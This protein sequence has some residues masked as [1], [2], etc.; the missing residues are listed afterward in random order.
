ME[1]YGLE[2]YVKSVVAVLVDNDQKKKY[3]VEQG[4]AKR[5]TL[6]GV[7]DHV[8]SPLAGQGYNLGNVG[9]LVVSI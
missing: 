6:E 8:V 3:K 5:L 2:A 9:S 7:R 4:K 1:E